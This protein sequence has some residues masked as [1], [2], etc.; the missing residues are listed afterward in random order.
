MHE[1]FGGISGIFSRKKET[2]LQQNR[3]EAW[4]EEMKL[5]QLK[6]DARAAAELP[7]EVCADEQW[8]RAV[9]LLFVAVL[10]LD[11]T[12]QYAPM[13]LFD[14][15]YETRLGRICV[16]AF[17]QGLRSRD[18]HEMIMDAHRESGYVHRNGQLPACLC[19]YPSN[20]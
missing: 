3:M 5:K 15:D 8:Q 12:M 17:E 16:R 2:K 14:L 18:V 13:R 9:E 4:C 6:M 7:S 20:E 1:I 10:D 11:L 19:I